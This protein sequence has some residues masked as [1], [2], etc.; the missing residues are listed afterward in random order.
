[1]PGGDRPRD[2]LSLTNMKILILG[3]G[4][5]GGYPQWNCN[6]RLCSGQRR[7]TLQACA[8]TQSSIAVSPDGEQ[9]L[10]L[11]ASPD[12]SHQI[13][14]N[15][16]LRPRGGLRGSPIRAILLTDAQ[17]D[18]TTGLLSLRE[19]P[20]IELYCTRS[21]FE[22]LSGALPIL[23][24]LEHYCGVHW[25]E[26]P[27][28][29]GR[30]EVELGIDG[31]AGLRLRA[32]AIPGKAPPYSPRREDAGVGDNIALLIEDTRTGQRVF[33]APG[34]ASVG[35]QELAWMREADCVMVD[36]T[37]WTEDEMIE[38][39]LGC[40]CASDMGHLSQM[41]RCGQAGMIA[42]LNTL[43]ARRKLLI[44]I[45]NSNP[46]LDECSEERRTLAR[47]GIEVAHDG[48]EIEL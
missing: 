24:T 26:L 6:C 5:G 36:G 21:V 48:L 23:T 7:G 40:K 15:A 44:H 18:H 17:I 35:E 41:G 3:S 12:V 9:W 37:F 34:L 16:A 46:I 31:I 13:R 22:D 47:H 28:D 20:P 8:R 27:I 14:S 19:G 4:A 1:M 10:L 30:R 38:A 32:L 39:G 45:N 11:N 2:H 42:A 29:D 25:H 43:G 33:Y